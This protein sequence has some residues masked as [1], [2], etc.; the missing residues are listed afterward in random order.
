MGFD[1]KRFMSDIDE[2]LICEICKDIFESP[3]QLTSCKHIF[4]FNCIEKNVI[5]GNQCPLDQTHIDSSEIEEAP[6]HI[7]DYLSML[8]IRCDFEDYGCNAVVHLSGLML[9]RLNCDYHPKRKVKCN[10]CG[11]EIEKLQLKDHDCISILKNMIEIQKQQL[12]EIKALHSR[13]ISL[14][15]A[16]IHRMHWDLEQFRQNI[17]SSLPSN[18]LTAYQ[19]PQRQM[20]SFSCITDSAAQSVTRETLLFIQTISVTFKCEANLLTKIGQIKYYASSLA[21]LNTND[22]S[23]FF[24]GLKLEEQYSLSYYNI[25][26]GNMFHLLPNEIYIIFDCVDIRIIIGLAVKTNETIKAITTQLMQEIKKSIP[27]QLYLYLKHCACSLFYND[28]QLEESYQ[29]ANYDVL[30]IKTLK[31]CNRIGI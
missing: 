15:K 6:K 16:Q 20:I 3:K 31:Y 29:L 8:K 28:I 14:M 4:C 17:T 21:N 2:S 7:L 12:Q 1:K 22:V 18:V 11:L 23:L 10:K 30:Q 13:E 9:H 26:N 27:E 24:N 25:L 5:N 19:T